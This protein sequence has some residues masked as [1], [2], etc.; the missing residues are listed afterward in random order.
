MDATGS[1]TTWSTT[2][3]SSSTSDR[4]SRAAAHLRLVHPF[5]SLLTSSATAGI[6]ALAGGDAWTV[7]RLF[8][9]MLWIQVAIGALNDVVDAPL[10]AVVKPQKPIPA[11]LVAPRTGIAIAGGGAVVGLGLSLVS[12]VATFLVGAACLALGWAY[13][14]RLSRTALS[15]LPLAL[16]LPLLPVHAWLG[17]TGVA[18][19]AVL[20]LVP[21]GILAGAGL[22][23]A[24]AI[25]D[26][27]RDAASG[28]N[29]FVVTLGRARAWVL[30]T[31]ILAAAAAIALVLAPGGGVASGE[32]GGVLAAV[33]VGGLAVGVALIGLGAL[34]LRAGR[35]ALRE[36]GWEL[37]AM[38]VAGLGIG[39]L[40]GAGGP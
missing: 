30:Q 34:V 5:P 16:A 8:L 25:V 14:V 13:D 12:G 10:D 40:A 37:E 35:P 6:A 32:A 26:A 1:S 31:A 2:S 28:R 33:R 19:P 29:G 9:A 36:R 4:A 18:P 7:A 21:V 3:T 23:L 24:N 38:G 11:G 27:D 39:W 15:W 20:E 17:A 22:A